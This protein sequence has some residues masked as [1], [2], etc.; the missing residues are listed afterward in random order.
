MDY[1]LDRAQKWLDTHRRGANE[2]YRPG[3]HLSIPLGWLNDP[4]GFCFFKGEYH[5]FCQYHPYDSVWGPMHWFHWTSSD[6]VHWRERAVA[7][8]PDTAADA[9]GCFSG[10]AVERDGKLYLMYTGVLKCGPDAELLQ[11]QCIAE[12]ADGVA[13]EKWAVNPVISAADLPEGASPFDFRDPKLIEVPGGWRAVMASRGANGGQLLGYFSEDMKRW[14]YDGVF[15]GGLGEMSECPDCFELDG[16]AVTV[17]CLMGVDGDPRYPHRQ[18]A[19]YMLGETDPAW[20]RFD[21]RTS[22]ATLDW[23]LDF[24]APQTAQ[25]PDGRRV[26]IGWA[27]SWGH[28]SPTHYMGHGWQGMMTLPRELSIRDGKLIQRPIR[29]LESLR[30]TCYELKDVAVEGFLAL[31]ELV[32]RR[33][34]IE[35]E[36]DVRSADWVEI[37]LM[38]SEGEYFSLM[39]DVMRQALRGDRSRCGY[40]LGEG[41]AAEEKPWTEAPCACE[42]GRLKLRIFVDTSIVEVFAQNGEV[43]MCSLAFP[44]GKGDG[45]SIRCGGKA[46]I[47]SGKRWMMG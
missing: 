45:V 17:V 39:Y 23:G 26:L 10:T 32:G 15:A 44:K 38:E 3:Y 5:L 19:A 34:E 16:Q 12:S 9:D 18:T 41:G 8:A 43:A 25:T 24:Y 2:L 31:S 29:E 33:A 28:M 21:A 4:N 22:P 14:R 13:F 1:T 37:R 42:E 47:V 6:L 40:P 46:Q 30:G 20:T 35:L 36:L 7:L 11:R 27:L